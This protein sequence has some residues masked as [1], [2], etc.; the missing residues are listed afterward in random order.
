MEF[1]ITDQKRNNEQQKHE[2]DY[3]QNLIKEAKKELRLQ[4]RREKVV[5]YEQHSLDVQYNIEQ[6]MVSPP[7]SGKSTRRSPADIKKSIASVAQTS[8]DMYSSQTIP[9]DVY[10]QR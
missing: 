9:A 6:P 4:K 10:E 2:N 7:Q 8:P 1:E 3:L 5:K